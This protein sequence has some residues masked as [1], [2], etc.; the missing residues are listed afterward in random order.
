MFAKLSLRS[1]SLSRSDNGYG[2]HGVGNENMG[3]QGVWLNGF[4]YLGVY[5][6]SFACCFS[7]H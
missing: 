7:S 6:L 3:L 5:E 2:V 1:R 4:V